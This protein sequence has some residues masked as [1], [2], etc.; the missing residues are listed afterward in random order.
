MCGSLCWS[1]TYASS[2]LLCIHEN[3]LY[4]HELNMYPYQCSIFI[5]DPSEAV[6]IYAGFRFCKN[7][8]LTVHVHV[9][10]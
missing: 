5:T 3:S 10:I 7:N 2:S 6:Q 8:F 4:Y 1:Q 9:C